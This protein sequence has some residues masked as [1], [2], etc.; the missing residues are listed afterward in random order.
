MS[1]Y[2]AIAPGTIDIPGLLNPAMV[3]RLASLFEKA[4]NVGWSVGNAARV[5]KAE[6]LREQAPNL[7]D[8]LRLLRDADT[9]RGLAAS[10]GDLAQPGAQTCRRAGDHPWCVTTSSAVRTSIHTGI[11]PP[12]C[13]LPGYASGRW[14]SCLIISR[15]TPPADL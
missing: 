6:V 15:C 14:S 7:K 1:R 8:L 2:S 5:A 3:D 12:T 13:S 11:L 4:T 9:R 10:A